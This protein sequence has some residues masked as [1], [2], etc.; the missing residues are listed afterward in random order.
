MAACGGVFLSEL[1]FIYTS[2]HGQH[3]H[4][5]NHIAHVAKKASTVAKL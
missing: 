2:V 5:V 3:S 4:V 1:A